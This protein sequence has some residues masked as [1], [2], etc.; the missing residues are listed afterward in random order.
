MKADTQV[1]DSEDEYESACFH[2][3][4]RAAV[5]QDRRRKKN[6]SD[7]PCIVR[8]LRQAHTGLCKVGIQQVCL[9]SGTVPPGHYSEMD[10]IVPALFH[11]YIFAALRPANSGAVQPFRQSAAFR[12]VVAGKAQFSLANTLLLCTLSASGSEPLQSLGTPVLFP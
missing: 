2:W 4:L 8:C 11:E 3:C 12:I 5:F 6:L 10:R 1:Y 9:M 7:E